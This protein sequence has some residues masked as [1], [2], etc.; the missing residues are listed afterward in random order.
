MSHLEYTRK[1][2]AKQMIEYIARDYIELSH[3]KVLW[4]RDD[5]RKTCQDWLENNPNP[6]YT[7]SKE[8]NLTVR[9][10][11][12]QQIMDCWR[13]TDDMRILTEEV[14][15][16]D[17]SKDQIANVLIG[18]EQLYSIKFDKMFRTFEQYIKE[19]HNG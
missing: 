16:G 19:N 9:F 15:E 4:Q 10:D 13:V 17:F 1:L 2:T 7:E 3:D 5:W 12:E 6:N 18:L 14:I 11:L 8:S